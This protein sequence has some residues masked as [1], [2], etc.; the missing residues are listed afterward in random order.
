MKIIEALPGEYIYNYMERAIK[1]LKESSWST[2]K[3]T[4]NGT[5]IL[6]YRRSYISDIC[7][8]WDMQHKL[9]NY[10]QGCTR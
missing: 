9:D 10:A 8:K 2:A 3:V 1:E 6:I 5:S 7:D 4:F